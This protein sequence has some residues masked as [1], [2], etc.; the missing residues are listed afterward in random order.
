MNHKSYSINPELLPDDIEWLI[1]EMRIFT[2]RLIVTQNNWIDLFDINDIIE[3]HYRIYAREY[4]GMNLKTG[5]QL[6]IMWE[7]ILRFLTV[8]S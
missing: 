8:Y 6:E 5:E 7:D 1:E 4:I 2:H 3:N